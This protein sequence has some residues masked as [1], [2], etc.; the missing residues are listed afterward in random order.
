M[1]T[2]LSGIILAAGFSS[3]AGTFKMELIFNGKP[4]LQRTVEAMAGVCSHITV[5][6]GHQIERIIRLTNGYDNLRVVMNRDYASGMFSSVKTG[7]KEVDTEWFFFTPG[8]YPLV[9][10]SVYRQ[11]LEARSASPE[12]SIF[13]PVHNGRKGHPVLMKGDLKEE[14]LAEPQDSNLK[15]FIN[16]KG[17]VPVETEENS[18][19]MD[20]DTMEDYRNATN[21]K[22]KTNNS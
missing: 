13:I 5:V 18:I 4:L 12:G 9:T 17:F 6:G 2:E 10:A 3:R 1:T 19:L 8:D 14:L 20:I 11:L 21:G 7:V 15:V 22:S 16:R